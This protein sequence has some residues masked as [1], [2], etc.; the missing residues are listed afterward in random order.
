MRTD[1]G[2]AVAAE[3]AATA[4][5][6]TH[7]LHL[8]DDDTAMA[9]ALGPSPRVASPVQTLSINIDMD[10][11]DDADVA[12]A[13]PDLLDF[14]GVICA[15]D[16]HSGAAEAVVASEMQQPSVNRGARDSHRRSQWRPSELDTDD[17][18]LL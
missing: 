14:G 11:G 13:L 3:V 17:D 8:E 6:T 2:A 12:V 4:E 7:M 16:P 18:D 1:R 5:F 9:D 15:R 10:G